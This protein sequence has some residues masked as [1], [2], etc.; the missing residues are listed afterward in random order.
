MAFQ[1]N[2]FID[3]YDL[4]RISDKI[5][6][7]GKIVNWLNQLKKLDLTAD[8]NDINRVLSDIKYKKDLLTKKYKKAQ[9]N[10]C[11]EAEILSKVYKDANNG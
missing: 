4:E 8:K 1:V 6:D 2:K 11:E 9:K 3:E 7:L 10:M 5:T